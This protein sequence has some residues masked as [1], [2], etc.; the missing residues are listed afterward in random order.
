ML[1]ANEIPQKKK[2]PRMPGHLRSIESSCRLSPEP[3]D[4]P[5]PDRGEPQ[6]G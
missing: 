5:D 1:H 6:H 4:E 3:T 2:V